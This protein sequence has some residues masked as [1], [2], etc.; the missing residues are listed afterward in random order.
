MF[1]YRIY[2]EE[3]KILYPPLRFKN[4]IM[5]AIK[6]NKD[7]V[8]IKDGSIYAWV[9]VWIENEDVICDWNQYIFIMTN[10]KE[11]ALKN[12]QDKLTNFEN[13]NSLAIKTL[14]DAKIIYQDADAK[15]HQ[16]EKYHTLKGYVQISS[17]KI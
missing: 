16:G 1:K 13:A 14:E 2:F 3:L 5:K 15:W 7:T 11:V 6:Y 17:K 8:L 10:P 12:W 9:D 4:S